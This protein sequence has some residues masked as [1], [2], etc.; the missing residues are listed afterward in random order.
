MIISYI[1]GVLAPATLIACCVFEAMAF[2][3]S[4]NPR[5]DAELLAKRR[6]VA[7]ALLVAAWLVLAAAYL[8]GR[9]FI[10]A[11]DEA[12]FSKYFTYV[13]GAMLLADIYV[14]YLRRSRPKKGGKK[15]F[16]EM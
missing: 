9:Y 6:N 14:L 15:R 11:A 2:K 8:A 16:W 12:L 7:D 4:K 5:C 1:L 13:L 3:L 10:A